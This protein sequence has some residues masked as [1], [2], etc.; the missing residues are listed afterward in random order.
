MDC[1]KSDLSEQFWTV[2]R[3]FLIR[4][5]L[6]VENEGKNNLNLAKK[7]SRNKSVMILGDLN[8]EISKSANSDP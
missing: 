4:E 7:V 3:W 2:P 8:G 5:M 1:P 6:L